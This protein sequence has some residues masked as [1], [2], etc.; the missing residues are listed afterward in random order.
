MATTES[1]DDFKEV[2]AEERATIEAADA[3]WEQPSKEFVRQWESM[4]TIY[5]SSHK[6]VAGGYNPNT[7]YF[8]LNGLTDLTYQ[9]AIDIVAS[10]VRPNDTSFKNYTY[11]GRTNL[12]TDKWVNADLGSY[13][14]SN[15][16]IEVIRCVP[17]FTSYNTGLSSNSIQ[18]CSKLKKVF[19]KIRCISANHILFKECYNLEYIEFLS[20]SNNS[21]RN[22]FSLKDLAKL[23]LE[24]MQTLVGGNYSGEGMTAITVTLHFDVY[25]KLHSALSE[26][27]AAELFANNETKLA[28][29]AEL[30]TTLT[31][32][33]Q[34]DWYQV[35]TDG[36]A[37]NITFASAT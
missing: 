29:W 26:E 32:Q 16:Y 35:V 6:H 18:L 2:T 37:R 17:D 8:E 4:C 19:G 33:E 10:T 15:S 28:R 3:E 22:S 20:G 5:R 24:S 27:E 21:W 25:A 14:Y 23:N 30:K 9:E 31:E 1:I 34:A 13:F 12:P 7:G 36:T 11:K